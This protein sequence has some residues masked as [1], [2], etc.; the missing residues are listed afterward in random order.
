MDNGTSA[1]L[2]IL[3]LA[4]IVV[5]IAHLRNSSRIARIQKKY[6]ELELEIS[7]IRAL[8]ENLESE[9]DQKP[10]NLQ[11]TARPK[12][13]PKSKVQV[14][15]PLEPEAREVQQPSAQKPLIVT[16]TN[17]S[18]SGVIDTWT[19]E[20]N[21]M[22]K[23]LERLLV[24]YEEGLP[25][26]RIAESMRVDSK[27]VVYGIARNVFSCTG[28]LEDL[29]LAPNDGTSWTTLQRNRVGTLIRSG[30]SIQHIANEY[31]RTQIA[32]IWQAID[33][34]FKRR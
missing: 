22:G 21:W 29:K 2:G 1:M 8:L 11:N 30:K 13:K 32:I 33:H 7:T 17:N 20:K 25:V 23:D 4:F 16:R 18:V 14:Q 34:G 27:D 9:K 31:G 12:E 28:N 10:R 19:K 24:L 6:L 15:E 26:R 3:A 5:F